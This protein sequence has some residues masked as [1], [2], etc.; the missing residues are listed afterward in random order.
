MLF[1]NSLRVLPDSVKMNNINLLQVDNTKYLGLYIDRELSWKTH[2]GYLSKILSRNTG[3]LNKLKHYFP[4]HILQ[5]IYSTLISP[6][7]N[8]GILAWGNA[9]KLSLDA[10]FRIQKRAV[11]NIN[12]AGFLS[13]T[14]HHFHQNR[15]LKLT[16][17]FHYNVGIF[18]F[19]LS[20]NELPDV[21]LH[22]ICLEETVPFMIIPFV[23]VTHIT[24]HVPA[25]SL[26]KEQ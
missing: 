12:H 18:M 8:Y 19:Q 16:D 3:I 7:L 1:S 9:N 10:L 17:L 22:I 24:F 15:I 25:L 23:S 4:C 6:Y 2:I 14:I 21:F 5:S 20:N 11:R 13:H 26:R